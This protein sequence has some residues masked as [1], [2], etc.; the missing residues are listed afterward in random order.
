MRTSLRVF[1]LGSL[2]LLV[3][4]GSNSMKLYTQSKV[5]RAEELTYRAEVVAVGQVSSMKSEWNADR[6]RITTRVTIAVHEYLKGGDTEKQLVVL[7]PG[8]E[9]GDVGEWY[10]GAARFN[11]EEEVVVFAKKREG[12]EYELAGGSQAKI[13]V[14]RDKRS[15]EK[16]VSPGYRLD[17][18]RAQVRSAAQAGRP[19]ERRP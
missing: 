19:G 16:L 18:F 17:D 10:S 9:V 4:P 15:G 1:A 8:G 2:L 13:R 12:R 6:T 3:L 14:V 5:L 7:T 11:R